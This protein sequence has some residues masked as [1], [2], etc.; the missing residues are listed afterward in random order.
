MCDGYN[1]ISKLD[2]YS[3]RLFEDAHDFFLLYYRN[4]KG[5]VINNVNMDEGTYE[6][7]KE[8]RGGYVI[9][10]IVQ[11]WTSN[12]TESSYIIPRRVYKEYDD[13]KNSEYFT[14]SDSDV[15]L[16]I[17]KFIIEK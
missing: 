5:L 4:D 1:G 2:E 11:S 6:Y 9:S 8:K 15:N 17:Q 3:F 13:A 12:A 7:V 14:N 10:E 16:F